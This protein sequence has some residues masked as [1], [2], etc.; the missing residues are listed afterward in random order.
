MTSRFKKFVIH[1][2]AQTA[3]DEE[4]VGLSRVH[5]YQFSVTFPYK[6]I[7]Y[8]SLKHINTKY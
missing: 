4:A 3:E 6:I 8:S 7:V 5:T 2:T 1:A